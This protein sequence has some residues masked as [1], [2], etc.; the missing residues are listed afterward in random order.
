MIYINLAIP[1]VAGDVESSF[2]DGLLDADIVRDPKKRWFLKN[3]KNVQRC[4]PRSVVEFDGV[5]FEINTLPK[6][7]IA[8]ENG[9]FQ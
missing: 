6:T 1:Q 5:S 9:G 8:P 7:N 2:R 4:H 3:N